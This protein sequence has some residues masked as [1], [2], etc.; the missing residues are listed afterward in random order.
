MDCVEILKK[1]ITCKSVTPD[2]GG[3]LEYIKSLFPDFASIE[4][5]IHGVKNLFLYKKNGEGK[6]LCFAGHVD[7]VPAGEGWSCDPFGA[8]EKDGYIYG[9]GTQDMKSGIAAFMSAIAQ[10][11]FQGTISMLLT[12]DEEGDGIYGTREMLAHLQTIAMLP[13]FAIVAEPTSDTKVCDAIKVGRRGSIN[14]V[15][16]LYG[17]QG[18]AAYPNKAK[19]P[20]D[21]IAP[22]LPKLAGH[23]FDSGDDFF[24]PSR[25]TITD[26][27]SGIEVSNVTPSELKMLFNVR[28]STNT[29]PE[30]IRSYIDSLFS[31][32]EY[33]LELKQGSMPFLTDRDSELVHKSKVAVQK[34][35]G[36]LPDC[37]TKGGTSD[38][39]YFGGEYGI[40]TVEIGVVNDRIHATDERVGID[41]LR[42]LEAVYATLIRSLS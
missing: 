29:K 35:C 6:H 9:R 1:L 28:N 8:E 17:K 7:V 22:L 24:E 30:D 19:N 10:S 23:Y 4:Q 40:D 14:G 41:E 36:Y 20:I 21:L 27:R 16:K 31:G 26:I 12:S 39:R 11:D 38:A 42:I 25:L 2:D 3:A 15:L 37:N 18:H 33:T 34:V 32:M 5:E 13:D